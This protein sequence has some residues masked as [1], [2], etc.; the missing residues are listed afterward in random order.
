MTA[1]EE[2][3]EPLFDKSGKMAE[4][5]F[6][7]CDCRPLTSTDRPTTNTT[8]RPDRKRK[9]PVK[10]IEIKEKELQDCGQELLS[11]Y[12]SKAPRPVR[13]KLATQVAS[14]PAR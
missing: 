13:P 7:A 2:K 4:E 5:F 8:F 9:A 14:T 3:I 6:F 10:I 12:L 11:P 1:V